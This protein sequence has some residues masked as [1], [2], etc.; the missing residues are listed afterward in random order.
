MVALIED[1]PRRI[2]LKLALECYINHRRDIIRRRS[3]FDLARARDRF[4]IV[5]GLLSAI[6]KI[7][8]I[9]KKIREADSADAAKQALQG[10]PF[11]LSERQAQAVL[12]MQLRRLAA[13]ERTK[14]E[15]EFQDL[16]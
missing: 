2:P 1:R 3:E 7:D 9:I 12:D 15:E 6:G 16:S 8:S 4:H 5:E 11:N 14:L 10:R 13:L